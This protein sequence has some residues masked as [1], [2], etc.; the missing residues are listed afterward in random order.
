MANG[1]GDRCGICSSDVSDTCASESDSNAPAWTKASRVSSLSSPTVD[2]MEDWLN[3]LK[4][5]DIPR[6][7]P[8]FKR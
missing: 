2:P 7:I 8:S 6:S 3:K 5:V 4:M 1:A